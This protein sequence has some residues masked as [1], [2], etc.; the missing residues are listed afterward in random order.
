MS[1]IEPD[2]LATLALDGVPPEG[3]TRAHLDECDACRA[4]YGAL[5]RTVELGRIGARQRELETPPSLVWAAIHDELS[6]APELAPDPLATEPVE[7]G[8]ASAIAPLI[9][10]T[11]ATDRRPEEPPTATITPLRERRTRG[12]WPIAAAAAAV[13]LVAG[14]AL[15]AATTGLFGTG[16]APQTIVATAALDSFPGWSA[17]GSAQ[18]EVDGGG[19]RS[20]VVDL[21][22]EVPA[23]DVREV[24]LIRSDASGLVSLGM[25]EGTSGRFVVP[26]GID[27]DEFTLVDVSAEPVDGDPAH[28]GDSIVRGELRPT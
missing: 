20:L 25:L 17:T 21:D 26:D 3:G 5:A 27:L 12:W 2:D 24:W 19:V 1:H 6:L 28:S 10:P 22:A 4:E 18:L 11:T 7:A 16:S 15:A 9:A 23:T 8:T 13:G 14:I